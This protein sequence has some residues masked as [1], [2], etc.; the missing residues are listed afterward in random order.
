MCG[1]MD[2]LLSQARNASRDTRECRDTMDALPKGF[3]DD[4]FRRLHPFSMDGFYNYSKGV[5][6]FR[7]D[8]T[9]H[10]VHQRL[11]Y[12][13][14]S[15]PDGAPPKGKSFLTLAEEVFRLIPPVA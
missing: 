6:R 12:V 10:R 9:N 13:L 7:D 1:I 11:T 14:L 3:G 4:A 8:A 15:C 2:S 5:H